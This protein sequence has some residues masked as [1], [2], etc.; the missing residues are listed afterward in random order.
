MRDRSDPHAR[1]RTLL[2]ARR[3]PPLGRLQPFAMF[4]IQ[5]AIPVRSAHPTDRGRLAAIATMLSRLALLGCG[6]L[7]GCFLG[8]LL[9]LDRHQHFLLAG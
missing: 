8:A 6:L 9:A 4:W 3:E 7:R 2:I 5:S 1:E